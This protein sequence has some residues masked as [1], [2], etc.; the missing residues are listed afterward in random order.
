MSVRRFTSIGSDATGN[1]TW[2]GQSFDSGFGVGNMII[3]N[4]DKGQVSVKA[5]E[6]VLIEIRND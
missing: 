4:Y 6:A 5:S 1:V 3:E 2:A